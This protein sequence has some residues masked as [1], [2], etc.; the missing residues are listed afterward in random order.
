MFFYQTWNKFTLES[1]LD[2][3]HIF[4]LSPPHKSGYIKLCHM[5]T[6]DFGLSD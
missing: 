2:I 3:P 1:A 5:V 6:R 4:T